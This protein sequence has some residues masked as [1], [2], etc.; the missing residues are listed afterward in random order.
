MR[1][2]GKTGWL[3]LTVVGIYIAVVYPLLRGR[4]DG[5]MDFVNE[6]FPR[7][8]AYCFALDEGSRG[9]WYPYLH[10][11]HSALYNGESSLFHPLRLLECFTLHPVVC[12]IVEKLLVHP[13]VLLGMFFFLR[14]RN[15]RVGPALFGAGMFAFSAYFMAHAGQ[16]DHVW[17]LNQLPW[18]ALSIE[19]LM[20]GRLIRG[21]AGLIVV[22]SSMILVGHPQMVWLSSIAV[23]L[24]FLHHGIAAGWNKTF[25]RNTGI[26]AAGVAIAILIGT[27]QLMPSVHG[28]EQ[29]D[30]GRLT[31][32]ERNNYSAHP[33]AIIQNIAPYVT[34]ASTVGDYFC[35]KNGAKDFLNNP[36]EFSVYF[37]CAALILM[38]AALTFYRKTILSGTTR[39]QVVVYVLLAVIFLLL[40]MGRYGYFNRLLAYAPL[41]SQFRCPNRYKL[42][43]A[44]WFALFLATAMNR[45]LDEEP[46]GSTSRWLYLLPATPVL[47]A[48]AIFIWSLFAQGVRQGPILYHFSPLWQRAMGPVIGVAALAL[49]VL[50]QRLKRPV[51]LQLLMALCVLDL[52]IFGLIRMH[53]IPF[54]PVK[55][56]YPMAERFSRTRQQYRVLA[57]NQTPLL[58]GELMANGFSGMPPREQLDF[59]KPS[60]RRLASIHR[61]YILKDGQFTPVVLPEPLKRFR[62]VPRI[63]H[64]DRPIAAIENCD[65]A[66]E[67][68]CRTGTAPELE[69][70]PLEP[71]E[72]LEM[73]YENSDLQRFALSVNHQRVLVL[74]DRWT[75]AWTARVDGQDVSCLPFFNG[76]LRGVVVPPGDHVVEFLYDP[77]VY[78]TARAICFA[79]I[80]LAVGLLAFLYFLQRRQSTVE[81]STE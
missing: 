75:P 18:L 24:L 26:A 62:L 59:S 17:I 79:G 47:G 80:G 1:A 63:R 38:I 4:L 19:W 40:T 7:R 67:V 65:L 54:H 35:F 32:Q 50:W 22:Y 42:V 31:Q 81:E 76:A 29:S 73:V 21:A 13:I 25:W 57:V 60:H 70:P 5:S 69:G 48:L 36:S 71:A 56:F 3:L 27:I 10:R 20:R 39:Y 2:L 28:L 49:F 12:M 44:F 9:F 64:V 45:L 15:L 11:G 74:S 72:Q 16:V 41:V 66:Q 46:K 6:H 23:S 34:V 58:R 51:L 30:R 53:E 55:D 14:E 77:P 68:L 8:A 78:Y 43:L 52:G 33:K 61:A 37:G